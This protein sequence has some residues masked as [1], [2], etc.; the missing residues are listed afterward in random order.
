MTAPAPP[1]T[2]M[3]ARVAHDVGMRCEPDVALGFGKPDQLLDDPEPRAVGDHVRMAAELKDST[4]LISRFELAPENVKEV[5]RGRV[6]AQ[7]LRPVHHKIDRVVADPLHGKFD[8]ARGLA[9]QQEF[10]AVDVCHQ[11][12]VIE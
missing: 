10:V 9:I 3:A 7:A 11:R 6:R 1:V 12:R 2:T 8:N 4:L 5:R